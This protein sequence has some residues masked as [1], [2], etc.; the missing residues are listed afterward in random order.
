MFWY[1]RYRYYRDTL[2]H[3][4]RKS[5]RIFY[6]DFFDNCKNDFKKVW[7]G[8]NDLLSKSSKKKS[9]E[10]SLKIGNKV[11]SNKNTVANHFNSF[12]TSIAEELVSKLGK[13]SKKFT[14]Y[15]NKP[16]NTSLF[17]NPVAEY[18][19]SDQINK[20][21]EKKSADTYDIPVKLIKMIKDQITGPL[22]EL[23]NI[24]FTTGCCAEILKYAKV[25]PIYKANSPLD[26]KNYRPISILPIF[27]KIMEKLMP[28]RVISFLE[29]NNVN[30]NQQ[31][32]F[33]KK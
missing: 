7:K 12:F 29:K 13:T 3:L 10:I 8:I 25:I 19:V 22:T 11:I 15:L 21:N 18:E 26:V 1:Q 4:I 17:L 5:K 6:K 24:S 20:L 32:G 9:D 2:N 14:D 33:Q 31:F 28:E 27:N 16:Q 23:I 30:F